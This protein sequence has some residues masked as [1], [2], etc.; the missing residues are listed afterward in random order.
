MET[1]PRDGWFRIDLV[2]MSEKAAFAAWKRRGNEI[3]A[4]YHQSL[5][6]IALALDYHCNEFNMFLVSRTSFRL[7]K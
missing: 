3:S 7:R 4:N 5:L 1:R 2:D 6:P